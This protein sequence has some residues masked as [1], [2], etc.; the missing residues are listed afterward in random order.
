[1]N[2][3]L[4]LGPQFIGR[5]RKINVF[6]L[7]SVQLNRFW[8]QKIFFFQVLAYL[9]LQLFLGIHNRKS[10]LADLECDSLKYLKND[11]R[12]IFK[13]AAINAFDRLKKVNQGFINF[14]L[15]YSFGI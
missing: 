5:K 9:K 10:R 3:N 6:G 14:E 11:L 13:S 12:K 15:L 1:M 4:K 8:F 2:K 7:R